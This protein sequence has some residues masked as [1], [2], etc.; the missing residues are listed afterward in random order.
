MAIAR[1]SALI[2]GLIGVVALGIAAGCSDDAADKLG[3]RRGSSS[4][5]TGDGG[6]DDPNDPNSPNYKPQEQQLFEAVEPDML[7]KCGKTCH[8]TGEYKPTPPTFLAG[9]DVYKTIKAHP[10]IVV[11]DTFQ[12]IILTKGPHAGP[13]V[14]PDI[15]PDFYDKV[16]KWLDAEALVIQ[17]QRKPSTDP[18]TVANGPNDIDLCAGGGAT[19]VCIGG[20]TGAHLTF[21]ATLLAGM[22]EITNLKLV[23][24]A[25][26]DVHVLKPQFVRITPDKKE[27]PDPTNQFDNVDQ[28]VPGGAATTLS[29]GEA[30]FSAATWRPFDLAADK[31]RIQADKVEPGKVQV[32]QQAPKCKDPATFATAVLPSMRGQNGVTPNCSSCHGNGTAN[33][34]LN[35]TDN[36]LI[37]Q[38]VLAKLNQADI[39]QSLIITKVTTNAGGHAG[40][41]INNAQTWQALFV[42]NKGVFF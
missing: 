7:A 26:T 42:N 38:T 39:T 9:P 3:S 37:C 25:G 17:S 11:A 36:N 35:G 16:K 23:A 40:G 1:G 13:G 34:T 8:E 27:T 15:D 30:F 22:L 28:T 6:P 4:G 41:A 21:D 20:L 14:S 10:G 12:S 2:F 19:G 24:A 33:I 29:T 5:T 18:L 32:I 31:I